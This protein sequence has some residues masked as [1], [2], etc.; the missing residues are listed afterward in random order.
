VLASSLSVL[1]F[2]DLTHFAHAALF[3]KC[4]YPWEALSHLSAY[5]KAKALGKIEAEV[6]DGVFLVNASTISIGPGTI[7]EPGAY[8]HGPCLIGANCTIRHGAYIRGDLLCGN[9]CIIGHAT[10]IKHSIMLNNAMAPH[11]NY[12]G[13][14]ILGNQTNLGAGVVCANL[15]LDHA[16]VKIYHADQVIQTNLKKLGAIIGDGSQIGCNS[17]LNPGTLLSKKSLI[18]PCQNIGGKKH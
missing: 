13:D 17:V 6:P 18:L 15:R 14:S 9:G 16:P 4:Q 8:I 12:V 2:F 3:E 5:L 10:E 1:D 11:F 7:I